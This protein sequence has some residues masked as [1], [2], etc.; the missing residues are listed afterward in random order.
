MG[1]PLSI[2]SESLYFVFS[3]DSQNL[4]LQMH[5][6]LFTSTICF[7]STSKYCVINHFILSSD[8]RFLVQ[9]HRINK[10]LFGR[11]V[12]TV[13][14]K[15]FYPRHHMASRTPRYRSGVVTNLRVDL[16][17]FWLRRLRR[18]RRKRRQTIAH[19]RII[20]LQFHI[21]WHFKNTG[22]N[23]PLDVLFRIIL[24]KLFCWIRL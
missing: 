7:H 23:R 6:S 5:T 24:Q 22:R 18:R 3:F 1:S 4:Q 20:R 15:N 9:H 19:P 8:N 17:G 12:V 10:L 13:F 14:N 16:F 11:W 2:Y 21:D